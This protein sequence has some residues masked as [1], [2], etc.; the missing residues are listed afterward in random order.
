[1]NCSKCTRP[2]YFSFTAG[3]VLEEAQVVEMR[4]VGFWYDHEDNY[5]IMYQCDNC[6]R[7]ELGGE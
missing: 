7:V 1:M 5:I 6:K 2:E 3:R 4:N